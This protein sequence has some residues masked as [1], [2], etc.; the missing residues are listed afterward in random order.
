MKHPS[1]MPSE[2]VMRFFTP[3]LYVQ[4]NS[5]D[6]KVADAASEA[7]EKA[8][9]EYQRH[10]ETIRPFMTS[11][12]RK[13]AE[14]NLHDADVLGFEQ[15]FQPVFPL[16]EPFLPAPFWSA[17]AILSLKQDKIIRSL[18]YVLWDRV[19]E[20][21]AKVD[22]PFSKLR[23]HWLYDE[24]DIA[25]NH[26]HLFLHRVL[27]SDGSIVEIPFVSVITS[28]VQLPEGD[29]ASTTRQIA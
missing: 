20:H 17:M 16:P 7:W 23:K 24:L 8:L 2:Q 5:S 29:E 6:D 14:L 28:G 3:Q 26:D 19:R 1:D 25:P 22:W 13:I 27:F 18:I 12:V 15:G 9:Q 10:L 21:S 4:F 11:Q